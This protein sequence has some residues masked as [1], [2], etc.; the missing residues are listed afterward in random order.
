M[1][2]INL[3]RS[4]PKLHFHLL[5][6]NSSS[7]S[8]HF[9]QDVYMH[10]DQLELAHNQPVVVYKQLVRN[11]ELELEHILEL[12]VVVHNQKKACQHPSFDW[13]KDNMKRLRLKPSLKTDFE[14]LNYLARPLLPKFVI[15]KKCLF[16]FNK[17][18]VFKY[19]NF[20]I[21]NHLLINA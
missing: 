8:N 7:C 15:V 17:T 3:G 14:H 20:S 12:V 13:G 19:H 2:S 21:N 11:P 1:K 6:V 10:F 4:L 5:K 18:R 16:I 9:R